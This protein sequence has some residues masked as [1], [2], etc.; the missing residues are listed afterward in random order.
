[1]PIPTYLISLSDVPVLRVPE[2]VFLNPQ[3]GQPNTQDVPVTLT[4]AMTGRPTSYHIITV[5]PPDYSI[6]TA[7]PFSVDANN[8]ISTV[9]VQYTRSGQY[10]SAHLPMIATDAFL[11]IRIDTI[12]LGGG[13]TATAAF[14]RI[15]GGYLTPYDYRNPDNPYDVIMDCTDEQG[16]RLYYQHDVVDTYYM[17]G[18][19]IG[20]YIF[21]SALNPNYPTSPKFETDLNYQGGETGFYVG[22]IGNVYL[23]CSESFIQANINVTQ[24]NSPTLCV[25][26]SGI[27]YMKLE[28]TSSPPASL[29]ITDI[30][31][32][33]TTNFSFEGS[34]FLPLKVF[35][36]CSIQ[37]PILF[38]PTGSGSYTPDVSITYGIA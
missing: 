10:P 11:S 21:F 17:T 38:T 23:D 8:P 19:A 18:V 2:V 22:D 30:T 12:D 9:T 13:G 4:K 3:T 20:K 14:D 28:N 5:Y 36:D 31:L 15:A 6:L 33:D 1:V 34:S 24:V 37:I 25:G 27:V 29:S 16:N 7:N 35:K 26:D 32:S